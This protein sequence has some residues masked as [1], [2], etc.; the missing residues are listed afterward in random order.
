MGEA[1]T[2]KSDASVRKFL[3]GIEDTEKRADCRTIAKMMRRATGKRPMMWGAS[4]VGYGSYNYRYA[5]GREGT[6]FEVGFSPRARNISIYVM[7]GF[8][9][10]GELLDRLGRHTTGKSCLYVGRLADVDRQVLE[11]LI[12]ESVRIMRERYGS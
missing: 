4:I 1:K 8:S 7:P 5:S 9:A 11:R 3:D 6:W 12:E 2:A 10:F